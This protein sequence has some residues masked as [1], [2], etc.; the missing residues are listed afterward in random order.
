MRI[1]I[2]GSSGFVGRAL[3]T[4]LEAAGHTVAGFSRMDGPGVLVG[5][6]LDPASVDRALA[7]FKPELIYHLAATTALK[8]A[9]A[10][11]FRANVDGT[12]NLLSAARRSA[13]VRRVVWMSSQ[14]VSRPGRVPAHDEDYAPADA[15]GESKAEGERLIR[16]ADGGGKE[17]VVV[18]STTIWGPGMSEHYAGVV[19]MIR[20]GLYFHV[21]RRPLLKSYSYIDNLTAQ[22]ISVGMAGPEQVAGRT[23]Y[24]ADSPPLDLRAWADAF[25]AE[26]G[27]R[28]YTLPTTVAR[29]LGLAGDVAH[30]LGL[31]APVRSSRITNMLTSYVY[32]TGPIEAVH[33]PTSISWREGVRRTAEWIQR[34]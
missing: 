11:G 24:L 6:L 5:D 23:F 8:G 9:P 22:L 28:I 31:P 33:G 17:W 4:A 18:R 12:A 32:D 29:L 30:A 26:F 27:R 16:A 20:R 10:E 21:G 1:L 34:A 2:T 3:V 19:R 15:Y 13:T 7:R 14:L 25:A